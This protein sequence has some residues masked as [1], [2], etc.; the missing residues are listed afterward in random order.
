MPPRPR[1]PALSPSR[2]ADFKQCPLLYRFRA[3]DRLPE[4]PRAAALRGT[5][6]H[7]VLERLFGLPA[8]GRHP[9][10]AR[11]LAAEVLAELE[12]DLRALLVD[13]DA[14]GLDEDAAGVGALLDTWFT[15]EDPRW[16]EPEACELGLEVEV[17][18]GAILRG[19]VDRL[20]V[21]RD[22]ALRVVDYKTGAA[23]GERNESRALFAMKFYAL[24]L[25]RLRGVVPSELRLV[26][27]AD[28]VVLTYVP[29]ADELRRFERTLAA[30]WAAIRRAAPTGDF[31]PRPGRWCGWCPH[32]ARCPAFGGTPPPYPGWPADP[33]PAPEPATALHP[34]AQPVPPFVPLLRS[35]ENPE[36]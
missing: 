6:V 26:Y 17:G 7:A 36:P 29:D 1:R 31:R 2:A 4:V 14:E 8:A 22:G 21:A 16:L 33:D 35:T 34:S 23:P 30:L 27:L 15:L 11:A 10:A 25:L 24:L 12:P 20:D 18:H 5:V 13:P 28:G 32:Q 9:E 3:I 19:Y